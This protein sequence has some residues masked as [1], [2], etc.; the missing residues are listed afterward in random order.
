[1]TSAATR[2]RRSCWSAYGDRDAAWLEANPTP[3]RV[4]GRMMFKRVMGKASFAKIADRSGQIQLFLQASTLGEAYEALQGLRRRRHPRRRGRAV[5]HQ[6]RRA[7][8]AGDERCGCWRSR[9]GRCRTSGTGWPTPSCAIAS[10]T[11]I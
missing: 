8:G 10:A 3:V 5:S 11:S 1:M 2:S 4:G 6:D 9:C 7:V